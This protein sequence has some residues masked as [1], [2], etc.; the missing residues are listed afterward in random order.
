MRRGS[1]LRVLGLLVL[2][3]LS[4]LV[5]YTTPIK[6]GLD[7]EGG[8]H[9]VLEAKPEAGRVTSDVMESAQAVIE[10]RV[11]ALGVAEPIVQRQ[12]DRRIIVQ[13]PG[14]HDQQEAID[15]IGKTAVLE[16]QDPFGNVVLTG[17]DLK[18]AVLSAD[19]FN[20]PAVAIEFKPEAARR[21]AELTS[22]YAGLQPIPILL[23]G[24]LLVA[25]VPEGAITDGQA[26]ITGN[27][28]IEEARNLAIQLQAGALPVP[29]DV[30]EVRNVGPVLGKESIDRSLRAGIFGVALV[31]VFMLLY[32]RLPGG[33]ADVALAIYIVL[34]LAILV[35][36]GATITLPGLA[37]FILSIGLAVDA[38]VLIFERVK[39]EIRAG[40]RLRPAIDAGFKRAFAA[41]LD[42][43]LTSLITSVVLFYF[44]TG[45]VKG[46]AVTLS[47]G[48]VTSMFTAIV[49]TRTL[50]RLVVD[51]NPERMVRYFGV[52][53]VTTAS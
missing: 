2:V 21:F 19:Q 30:A 29:L 3:A 39:E 37:G 11:N 26:I 7:L 51:R 13:L 47:V 35:G 34:L 8:V 52:K 25:P 28:T 15:T 4:G 33:V 40:K 14:V 23:D 24:D 5:L 17:A 31:L 38:N 9:V 22:R 12:G 32:Y 44:G 41:I 27:F 46:F 53:E 16:I 1:G 36:I 50:L 48:I 49:V 20:R 6:W 45:P 10:R 42:A 43:N 18:S